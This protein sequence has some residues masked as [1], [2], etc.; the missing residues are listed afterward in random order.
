MKHLGLVVF[1]GFLSVLSNRAQSNHHLDRTEKEASLKVL[2]TYRNVSDGIVL[3]KQQKA[4][5]PIKSLTSCNTVFITFSKIEEWKT[6]IWRYQEC[7]VLDGN[8]VNYSELATKS[9]SKHFI[10][11]LDNI[12][13]IDITVLSSLCDA[14]ISVVYFGDESQVDTALIEQVDNFLLIPTNTAIARDLSVQAIFGALDIKGKLKSNIS[15]EFL[16]G[17]G[18]QIS[19]NGRLRYFPAESVGISGTYIIKTVDS[20]VTKAIQAGAFPGCRVLVAIKG[21]VIFNRAYGYHTYEKRI[22]VQLHD[23]YDLASV[24]KITGPLPLIM[25]ACDKGLIDLDKPFSN[26]WKDWQTKLFHRSNKDKISFREVLAHQAQLKPY[27]NYY[28]MTLKDNSYSTKWY[29]LLPENNNDIKID[30]HLYLSYKFKKEVYKVIRKSTLLPEKKYKYSGLSYMIYPE[31]LSQ[32]F[33]TDYEAFL[34]DSVCKPLGAS[35]LLYN[36]LDKVNQSRIVPT[37]YDY[38]FRKKQIK[39]LV[40]DE[41]AAIMG[42]VSG[43][44]GLFAKADDLAKVMQM[45]LNKGSYAGE[46]YI[47]EKTFNNFTKVQYPE[48][49][50]RRGAGFDKPLLGNDTLSIKDSYPAPAVSTASF[51]HSGF[52][53]TFVWVD[54]E[55]EMVFIFLSNRV[56]PTRDNSLI[57]RMNVRPNIQQIF[58]DALNQLD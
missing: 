10:L 52:T 6:N 22:A 16:V 56:Y 44:A 5:F 36:P 24:T 15:E 42:G 38:N 4:N 48:N 49:D 30:Q 53:G 41:A 46:V 34:Y 45:Y 33:K 21:D 13:H 1:V 27:I 47:S 18:K 40:H 51:G 29:T 32:I 58:Y 54:P 7:L 28:P 55:Y 50:N 26:Y 8:K 31:L 25:K 3:V 9:N 39:G 17:T 37:E 57:Y 43:N 11:L 20:I 12:A 19:A 14:S 35:S 2:E 23:I